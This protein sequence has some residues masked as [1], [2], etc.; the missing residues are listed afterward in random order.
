MWC[1]DWV[2]RAGTSDV[3]FWAVWKMYTEVPALSCFM[4]KFEARQRTIEVRQQLS[5]LPSVC[6]RAWCDFML[7]AAWGREQR[8]A[9][10]GAGYLAEGSCAQCVWGVQPVT[11]GSLFN[12]SLWRLP[13]CS[14]TA[15]NI[16][17]WAAVDKCRKWHSSHLT[18]MMNEL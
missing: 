18:W 2:L 10:K 4:V 7:H 15:C 8:G 14:I 9:V 5:F 6:E 17:K 12:S 3:T 16:S 11:C 1:Y 13:D